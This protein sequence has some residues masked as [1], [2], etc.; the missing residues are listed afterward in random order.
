MVWNDWSS[1]DWSGCDWSGM[2]GLVLIDLRHDW[3]GP[4]W[5]GPDWSENG[6]SGNVG[7]SEDVDDYLSSC[8][9]QRRQRLP[10]RWISISLTLFKLYHS[11]Q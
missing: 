11:I 4:D 10:R 1:C 8:G 3:A 6:W 7:M 5:S 2:I 9:R